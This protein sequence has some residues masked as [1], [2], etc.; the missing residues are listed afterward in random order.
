MLAVPLLGLVCTAN[1]A[2]LMPSGSAIT[3]VLLIT[4]SSLPEPEAPLLTVVFA[5][6]T[7]VTFKVTVA[8]SATPVG[9]VD[10]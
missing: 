5:S 9:D 2:L 3:K 4:L 6:L 7:A 1:F 8:V 10:V